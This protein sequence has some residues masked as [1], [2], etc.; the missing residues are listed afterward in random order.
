M[1]FLK[2]FFILALLFQFYSVQSQSKYFIW[3]DKKNSEWTSKEM[4]IWQKLYDYYAD[5]AKKNNWHK[6][7]WANKAVFNHAERIEFYR[8]SPFK[9]SRGGE[10][11]Y[12]QPQKIQETGSYI[13]ASLII[14]PKDTKRSHDKSL[15]V[16]VL[17]K[18]ND[19]YLIIF[20][21]YYNDSPS[22]R[23]AIPEPLK[24]RSYFSFRPYTQITD[25]TAPV[26]VE[27]YFKNKN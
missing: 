18:I 21:F 25:L 6:K 1:K 15:D 4:K 13:T 7:Y 17:K 26:L 11:S 24:R 14:E 8:P 12:Y 23:V 16:F 9:S 3:K 19:D 20:R 5:P 10:K 22:T 2:Y 27:D